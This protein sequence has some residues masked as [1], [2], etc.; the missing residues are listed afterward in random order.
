MTE[1]ASRPLIADALIDPFDSDVHPEPAPRPTPVPANSPGTIKP[2]TDDELWS[3]VAGDGKRFLQFSS[4]SR[5]CLGSALVFLSLRG[6]WLLPLLPFSLAVVIGGLINM[7]WSTQVP[8]FDRDDHQRRVRAGRRHPT[9]GLPT[10]DVFICTCGEDALVVENTIAHATFLDYPAE[11]LNVHVLDDRNADDIQQASLRWG[12]NYIS[13]PNKGWMKKAGNLHYGYAQ[14]SGDLILVLDADFAVRPDFLRHTLPYFDDAKLGILQTPQ[15]FRVADDNWVERGAAAQ[16]EQFYRVG[17]R[18]RDKHGGAIC[19]GTNAVYRRSALDERGGMA[20]LEHSEDIFTGMK[21]IDAGYRVDYLPLPLAAGSAPDNAAALASQ[22]YRWARGNFALAGTPLFKRMRLT[23]MQRLGIWDGWIFYVTSALSPLVALYVPI[24]CLIEAPHVITLAPAAMI[25]PALFTEFYLQPRWLH[26]PDGR[27]SRRVGLISQVA[28]LYAMRDH[29]TDRDQE[30]IPTGGKRPTGQKKGTDRIPDQITATAVWGFVLIIGLLA[31]RMTTGW[32]FM[33]LAPVGVLAAIA[34]PAALGTTKPAITVDAP[35]EASAPAIGDGRDTFLDMVR[36]ISIV[37]VMFWHALGY[38]W[39]SWAFAAMPAVFY[40]AGAVFAKSMANR[41]CLTVVRNRLRRLVLPYYAF[42][43]LAL[44]IVTLA[45]PTIGETD[46]N[47]VLSWLIPYRAPAPLAW[48]EGWLSAPLWFLRALVVVLVLTPIVRPIGKRL[49]G[50][51]LLA[52]WGASLVALDWWVDRQATEMATAVVRG[53]ADIVCFGGFF[54]LGVSGHHLRSRLDRRTR[55]EL[56]ALLGLGAV[57]WAVLFPP[58]DGVV[59]NS[60]VLFGLVGLAWLCALLAIEDHLRHVGSIPAIAAFVGWITDSAM[61]IYL[62][63]TMALVV[64]YHIVGAPTSLGH[65]AVLAGVFVVVL[66]P[67]VSTVRPLESLGV[68]N[69]RG[70]RAPVY[71]GRVLLLGL[72]IA[73]LVGQGSLFPQFTEAVAPPTPSGRPPVGSEATLAFVEPSAAELDAMAASAEAWLAGNNVAAATV[74]EIGADTADRPVTARFGAAEA[75]AALDPS[76]QFEALSLTKTMVAA[77]ALQ[78]VDEGTLSLDGSLPLVEGVPKDV[79]D[80]LSLRRLLSHATGLGDYRLSPEFRDDV[81]L[82]PVDA[83]LL[84]LD[85]SD[86]S[87]TEPE[88]AA[89]NY[90]LAGLVIEQVTGQPLS[91]VLQT[92]LFDPLGM[93]DTELVN[94]RRAGFIGHGS[95][96]VVSTL[97]DLAHW[98]DA[99]MR[100]DAVLSPEMRDE[101]LW[102][103]IVYQGNAGLGSWRHC[104]CDPPSVAEPEPFLYSFHDGGDVRLVYIPSRDQ[105]LALRFSKSLYDADQIVDGI[106]DIIF[107][108]ADRRDHLSRE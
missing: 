8:P 88:Y 87:I 68:G 71:P 26:L 39:I 66:V 99:L 50:P 15:Y 56:V 77:A 35:V 47:G 49:P 18:A 64:A 40:V 42:V 2:P 44:T 74:V 41:S 85:H 79:T 63:H 20:L 19:V 43:G 75:N 92:R 62:W 103:G 73:V 89:T 48:E 46:R 58:T 94:N 13:R 97:D 16:Q 98:Y 51:L 91:K 107:A 24:V 36:A 17:M 93:T 27:A 67:I 14:T 105:V 72:V 61:S 22:Q 5:I 9:A 108:V 55:F 57:V 25:L 33:D 12:A 23:P 38:W 86:L 100:Q 83:V 45:V 60:Y 59:N 70:A 1:V 11:L 37:R 84:G 90:L 76:V 80:Q 95:A 101:M 96:G 4:L 32:N 31:F 82:T 69:R 21:V 30:W 52:A 65:Y 81:I 34:L 106:D 53:I 3:Y 29:L 102:G 10:V 6:N 7:I 78:L 28:H 54:A 104:P